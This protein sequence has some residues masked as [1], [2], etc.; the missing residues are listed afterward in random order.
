MGLPRDSDKTQ[1]NDIFFS[2]LH[3]PSVPSCRG[4]LLF[5]AAGSITARLALFLRSFKKRLDPSVFFSLASL[6]VIE[7]INRF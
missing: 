1:V 3:S 7:S 4:R 6:S 2:L 5:I